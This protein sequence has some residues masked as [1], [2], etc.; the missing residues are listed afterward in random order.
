MIQLLVDWF[1][2]YH[3]CIKTSPFVVL[4]IWHAAVSMLQA[5]V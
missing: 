3:L 4:L 1:L 5:I 2:H